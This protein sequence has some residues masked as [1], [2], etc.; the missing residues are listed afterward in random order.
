[1]LSFLLA[2]VGISHFFA[3]QAI[4]DCS[5]NF[6]KLLLIHG[7]ASGWQAAGLLLPMVKRCI[8]KKL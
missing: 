5:V 8:E 2:F 6:L 1:M 3:L 4:G 7:L